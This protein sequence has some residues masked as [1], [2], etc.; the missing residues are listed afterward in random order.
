MGLQAPLVE[1]FVFRSCMAAL[2]TH[3]PMTATQII[4]VAPM[5]FGLA[6]V[7]HAFEYYRASDGSRESVLKIAA[8]TRA[9]L[10]FTRCT[11]CPVVQFTYTTLFGSFCMLVFLASRRIVPSVFGK[12]NCA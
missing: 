12:A 9:C 7:H 1:E 8:S 4:V 10:C 6:H 5:L 2:L 11:N 3:T